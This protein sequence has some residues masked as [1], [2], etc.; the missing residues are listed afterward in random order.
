MPPTICDGKKPVERREAHRIQNQNTALQK[1][2][3]K[4]AFPEMQKALTVLKHAFKNA[5][6]TF[7]YSMHRCVNHTVNIAGKFQFATLYIDSLHMHFPALDCKFALGS[8][9]YNKH[10]IKRFHLC[11]A[12]HHTFASFI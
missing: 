1:A 6:C 11:Y 3:D 4:I 8:H 12:C 5:L 2:C 9:K 10:F 7:A